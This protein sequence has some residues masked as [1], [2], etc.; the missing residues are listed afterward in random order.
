LSVK[1]EDPQNM[2]E[3]TIIFGQLVS[4]TFQ[5]LTFNVPNN[6]TKEL[7][8]KFIKFHNIS[9]DLKEELYKQIDNYKRGLPLVSNKNIESVNTNYNTSNDKKENDEEEIVI[10]D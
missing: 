3:N 8:E 9:D 2:N 6:K 10:I 5:I 7:I 1:N 4:F